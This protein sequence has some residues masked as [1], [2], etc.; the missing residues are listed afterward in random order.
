MRNKNNV[1]V[2]VTLS[3]EQIDA[4]KNSISGLPDFHIGKIFG[5]NCIDACEKNNG[6]AHLVAPFGLDRYLLEPGNAFDLVP[7]LIFCLIQQINLGNHTDI[8]D[9]EYGKTVKGYVSANEYDKIRE[10]ISKYP[11]HHVVRT[12]FE[13][14][15]DVFRRK[16][17]SYLLNQEVDSAHLPSLNIQFPA[18]CPDEIF[19]FVGHLSGKD[20]KPETIEKK[21]SLG[22]ELFC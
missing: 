7:G 12:F 18:Y 11:E 20:V 10:V 13:A 2:D 8:Y 5:K 6:A 16:E 22:V 17:I 3:E 21:C 1:F 9:D 4:L 19:Q 15:L 14:S